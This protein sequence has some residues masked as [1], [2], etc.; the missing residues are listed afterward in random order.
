MLKVLAHIFGCWRFLLL[1]F[2]VKG[3]CFYFLCSKFLL[4]VLDV[5]SSCSYSWILK[6]FI[7]VLG[8]WRFLLLNVD[9]FYFYSWMLKVYDSWFL[10]YLHMLKKNDVKIYS[11]L[12]KSCL[13]KFNLTYN[14]ERFMKGDFFMIIMLQMFF[15]FFFNI[16]V[17]FFF[18]FWTFVMTFVV[19]MI[20][21]N[22]HYVS[23]H[24]HQNYVYNVRFFQIT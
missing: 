4:L 8:C 20:R 14:D 22:F 11:I 9:L 15:F 21:P 24:Q 5:E 7:F 1:L 16:F 23:I 2:D 13:Y 12:F 6:V 18:F 17:D 19:F 10:F 3:Y